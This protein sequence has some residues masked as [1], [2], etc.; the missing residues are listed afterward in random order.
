MRVVDGVVALF[1]A[2][3]GVQAQSYTVLRQSR[4]F[5]VPVIA[6][7][8]KMD[9]FNADF[10]MAVGTIREKLKVEPLLLQQP[11]KGEDGSFEGVIDLIAQK[12]LRFSGDHG[13]S[14]AVQDLKGEHTEFAHVVEA[15]VK[16]RSVLIQ[17]LTASDDAL[18]EE[19]IEALDKHDGDE[20]A[21]EAALSEESLRAAVRRLLLGGARKVPVMPVLC[22]ASRRDQ[23]VQPLLDAVNYYLPSPKD[24]KLFG[25]TKEGLP[26]PLP[27]VSSAAN[28]P[29]VALAFKV[30][31]AVGPNGRAALVFLRVY[32]GCITPK[33]TLVNHTQNKH[34]TID[35]LYVMHAN[36]PVEVPHLAA[37]DIGAA[38]LKDTF[39]GDTLSAPPVDRT[40]QSK[41][42]VKPTEETQEVYTLEGIEAPPA[43]LS[44]TV[45]A[46]NLKHIELLE[47]AL[48]ELC[49][50]D[51][52][53]RV[54]K[55]EFGNIVLRGMGELHLEIALSR[56]HHEFQVQCRLLRAVV[57]YREALR[58]GRAVEKVLGLNQEI[59][60]ME[61]SLEL[62]PMWVDE[63]TMSATANC[64]FG[65]DPKF[66]ETYV[67]GGV[68]QRDARSARAELQLVE[69]CFKTAVDHCCRL[70]PMGGLPMHGLQVVLT[71]FRKVTP[72]AMQERIL[73]QVCRTV[74]GSL[75]AGVKSSEV[76]LVEPMMRV[77]VH[78]SDPTFIG[79][80]VTSLNEHRAITVEVLE[81]GRSVGAIVAMRNIIRYTTELRKAVKG[82]AN[83]LPR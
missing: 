56:L 25:L 16:G 63:D 34:Q 59:P 40:L 8:N 57:E 80:V 73:G 18:S 1:D 6:F 12:T 29:T 43:V 76:R 14:V 46:A 67:A 17:Q 22:G 9:K 72:N 13:S 52:S 69:T 51:P 62:R 2:S 5:Q 48:G 19:F 81:D 77:E 60:Y 78:L 47:T 21:S 31:H 4:K 58:T 65:M 39:T 24:R 3:A 71:H 68:A 30:T 7:I 79:A 42:H 11:L 38:F 26:V 50:E 53:L 44:F 27:P 32:C 36:N 35:K 66:V 70:G 15:A 23:G 74:V 55:S 10:H 45:E 54:E 83:L 20:V 82:H 28:V 75:L 61:C 41:A 33:M 49:R 64:S 37:G